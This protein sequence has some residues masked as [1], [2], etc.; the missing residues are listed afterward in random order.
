MTVTIS[1]IRTT[2]PA[3]SIRSL[4]RMLKSRRATVSIPMMKMWP[5]SRTGIGSRF[6]MPRF[7]E[8]M[9]MRLNSSIHPTWAAVPD[10]WAMPTGPT[11]C[12]GDVSAVISPH[13][14]W[15]I[16]PDHS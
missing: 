8:I 7:S 2:K 1:I 3:S 14:V 10:N 11:S 15:K 13:R 6:R 12:R 9:A 5:P 16:S 4:T